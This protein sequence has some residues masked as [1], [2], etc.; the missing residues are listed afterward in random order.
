MPD[1]I[2]AVVRFA[3]FERRA[4]LQDLSLAEGVYISQIRPD[5]HDVLAQTT[6]VTLYARFLWKMKKDVAAARTVFKTG[7]GQ[8]D[9]RFYFSNYL[10]FEMDQ[11]GKHKTFLI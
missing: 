1:H 2:E 9:S 10:K 8:F 11:P 4:N 6:I 7:E 3:N 5:A